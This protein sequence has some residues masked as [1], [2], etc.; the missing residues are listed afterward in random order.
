[1][2]ALETSRES[3]LLNE[4]GCEVSVGDELLGVRLEVFSVIK[5]FSLDF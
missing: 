5:E 3:H 2:A 4:R 1:M